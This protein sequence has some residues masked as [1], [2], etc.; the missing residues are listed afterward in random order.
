MTISTYFTAA[1]GGIDLPL[2][3]YGTGI[4]DPGWNFGTWS[5]NGRGKCA[6]QQYTCQSLDDILRL[7]VGELFLDDAALALWYPQYA[8]PQYWPKDTLRAWG[9]E[10]KTEGT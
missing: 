4:A 8:G 10:P 9:F 7:P 1:Q 3:H 5:A 2:G 6:D